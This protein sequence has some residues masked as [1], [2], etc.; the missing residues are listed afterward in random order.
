MHH[1][2]MRQP[3]Y[4]LHDKECAQ[5]YKYTNPDIHSKIRKSEK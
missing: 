1:I 3:G 2:F 4:S 5:C